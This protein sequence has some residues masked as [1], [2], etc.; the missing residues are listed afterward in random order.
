MSFTIALDT[1]TPALKI[2]AGKIAGQGGAGRFTMRWGAVVRKE[3]MQKAIGKGG[4]RFWRQL[5]RSIN[6]QQDGASA[7]VVGSSHVA[8]AQKQYGGPIQAKGSGAGGSN[9]LTIPIDEEAEGRRAS[10]F[11]LAGRDLFV[12]PGTH[13]LGYSEDGIFIGLFALVKRTAPQRPDPFMPNDK[14][15]MDIGESEA[16]RMLRT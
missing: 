16:E 13:V 7:A 1:A 4:R 14:R 9:W 15:T 3:A 11:A 8:A 10:D 6:L 2:M 5:A 12:A